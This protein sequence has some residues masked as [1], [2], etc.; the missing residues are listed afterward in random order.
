MAKLS[1]CSEYIQITFKAVIEHFYYLVL[2]GNRQR[3]CATALEILL[4]LAEKPT[5]PPVDGAERMDQDTSVL[6]QRL[7]ALRR[8]EDGTVDL[9]LPLGQD[10]I[11]GQGSTGT[12]PPITSTPP[13]GNICASK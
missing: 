3:H 1:L 10:R 11:R 7:S 4:T 8:E 9:E 2:A 6:F 5:S 12:V 13:S